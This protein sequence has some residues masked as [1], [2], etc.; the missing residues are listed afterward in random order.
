MTISLSP[1]FAYVRLKTKSILGACM[2]HGMINGTAALFTLYIANAN[3][4]YSSIAG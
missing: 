4:L 1:L 2:L 3:E